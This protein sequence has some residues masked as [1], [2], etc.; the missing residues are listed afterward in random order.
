MHHVQGKTEVVNP[1]A[2][3]AL[4]QNFHHDTLQLMLARQAN[5]RSV[6]VYDAN[7][8]YQQVLGRQDVHVRWIADAIEAL[9][10]SVGEVPSGEVPNP[11]AQKNQSAQLLEQDAEAQ[12]V[13][14]DRW[15]PQVAA[16]THAR[17]RKL[18]D[19]ILGEMREHQRV[20]QQ[21]TEGRTDLLGRHTDGKVL[22]GS[23][24]AARPHG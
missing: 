18:L 8:A 10:G 12:R 2:L 22:S 7:N 3:V 5:A 1:K 6:A 23:V 21:G 14:L 9:G 24:M 16:V 4:L 15:A 20:F 13:F 11:I 19:L 17:N